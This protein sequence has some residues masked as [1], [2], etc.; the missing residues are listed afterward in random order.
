MVV[1]IMGVSGSG[2]STIGRML[3]DTLGWE[4]FD[5]DSFHTPANIAKMTGGVPLTESDRQPWLQTLRGS[6]EGWERDHRNVV[7][8][9]S[10]LTVASR[11]TL[12][13]LNC[14][15]P[16]VYLKGPFEL[17]QARLAHRLHHFMP[18][19]LLT[20]QFAQL[21]EP[22]DA[23]VINIAQVPAKILTDIKVHLHQ[24]H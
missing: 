12:I 1:V 6:I 19:N 10:A 4:F 15:I 9:C 23:I 17:I 5:A 3:A 13:P 24:S 11:H 2:K 21:E 22:T 14:R 20:D 8:A 7:L 16:L 18:S